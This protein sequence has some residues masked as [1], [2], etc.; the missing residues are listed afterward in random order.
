MTRPLAESQGLSFRRL[1]DGD[2]VDDD[3]LAALYA[4]PDGLTRCWVRG[5]AISTLDGG[6]TTEGT[7]GGLGKDGDRLIF[8]LLREL[9]DVII[10]GAGTARTENYAG[11]Q[12]NVAQRRRRQDRGQQEVPPI[13][14]VTRSG[15][16]DRHQHVLTQTEVRPLVMTCN[17]AVAGASGQLG[18]AAEVVD[19]SGD[20]AA[21]VDPA[22][23]LTQ[24][25]D[26]GLYRA[27]LE[28][29]PSLLGTFVQHRLVDELCLT[30][31]PTL[32]GG[33]AKRIA[34]GNSH[35]LTSMRRTHL[36]CDADGYLYGRYT[37][38][39]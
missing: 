38:V 20:D 39:G 7:S 31:A 36:I 24:L 30:L 33:D 16:I 17:N 34:T 26:R 29:G 3:R 8:Q 12:M 22:V 37:R 2:A 4:Y 32:V 28:G 13:A 1:G 15:Q 35:E 19:C 18:S 5:N 23:V 14:L 10:V 25:A 9:A 11:A 21:A 27:L 6:A